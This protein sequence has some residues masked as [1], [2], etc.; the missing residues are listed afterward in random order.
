MKGIPAVPGGPLTSKP[1][2]FSTLGCLTTPAFF[3]SVV[4]QVRCGEEEYHEPAAS[5]DV[6]IERRSIDSVARRRQFTLKPL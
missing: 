4:P 5:D 6:C 1:T 3:V 2:W